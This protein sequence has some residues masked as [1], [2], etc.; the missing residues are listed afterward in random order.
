MWSIESEAVKN[1]VARFIYLVSLMNTILV[2]SSSRDITFTDLCF[3]LIKPMLIVA[4]HQSQVVL[5]LCLFQYMA[6]ENI[7][8]KSTTTTLLLVYL[9]MQLYF[10]RTSH[11]ERFSSIQFAKAFLGF[12]DYNYYLHGFLVILNT[13]SSQIIG[14]LLLP[15]ISNKSNSTVEMTMRLFTMNLT[16]LLLSSI[17]CQVTKREL[18]F[19]ERT[20]PKYI[21]DVFQCGIFALFAIVHV[22]CS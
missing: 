18:M 9:T 21:F 8:D 5:M 11:R 17:M 19:P 22:I 1:Q 16:V 15:L 6:L 4:G 20:A 13:Y 7:S 3:I 10:Y 14:F 12:T 2:I